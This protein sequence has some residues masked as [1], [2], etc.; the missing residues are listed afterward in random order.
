MMRANAE[1]AIKA[2]G[3]SLQAGIPEPVK[4]DARDWLS[5]RDIR[6]TV[7]LTGDGP[8]AEQPDPP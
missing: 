5:M 8:P 4:E 1:V 6:E 2:F 7:E 3:T